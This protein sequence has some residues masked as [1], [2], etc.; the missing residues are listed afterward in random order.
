A[1]SLRRALARRETPALHWSLAYTLLLMGKYAQ[2]W[3]HFEHRHAALGL[4]TASPHKARWNGR[5]VAGSTLLILDE[6]GLGDT[7]QFLRFLPLI[8][9]GLDAR[10]IFAGKP[11]VLPLV[12]RMLPSADVY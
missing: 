12:R 3:P 4:R 2:A 8:P 11:A 10:I 7:L 9:R 6:Q 5:A 1:D